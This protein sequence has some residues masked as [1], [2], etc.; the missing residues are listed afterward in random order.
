G[1]DGASATRSA[2][3]SKGGGFV[4]GAGSSL[5]TVSTLSTGG[6]EDERDHRPNGSSRML[7]AI[8]SDSARSEHERSP[9]VR[10]P[11]TFPDPSTSATR[12][13]NCAPRLSSRASTERAAE[14]AKGSRPTRAATRSRKTRS[15]G[16]PDS[17]GGAPYVSR[18]WGGSSARATVG[19]AK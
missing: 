7:I 5:S 10:S 8:A 2:R 1:A 11:R 18:A 6:S 14:G 17:L 19:A 4:D 16:Q 12:P 3:A 13:K 15:L 9:S